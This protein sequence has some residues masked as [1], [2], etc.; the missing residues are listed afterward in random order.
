MGMRVS[1][2][3]RTE[4]QTALACAAREHEYSP[5]ARK[6][7]ESLVTAHLFARSVRLMPARRHIMA[8]TLRAHQPYQRV[9]HGVVSAAKRTAIA[10][11]PRHKVESVCTVL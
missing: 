8:H 5:A 9:C 11:T 7:L 1:S 10:C 3:Q 2:A 4:R 6:P